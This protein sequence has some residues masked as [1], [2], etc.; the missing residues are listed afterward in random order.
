MSL[1][2]MTDG[3]L[4]ILRAVS[5]LLEDPSSKITISKIAKTVHVTDAAI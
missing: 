5:T 2:E 1:G 4:R 3:K